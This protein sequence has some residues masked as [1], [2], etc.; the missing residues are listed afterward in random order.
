[1]VVAG[2][3]YGIDPCLLFCPLVI[4]VIVL[5]VNVVKIKLAFACADDSIRIVV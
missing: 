4:Y 3:Y 5:V 2:R 1:M